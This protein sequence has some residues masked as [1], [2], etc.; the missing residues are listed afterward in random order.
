MNFC[1]QC[2]SNDIHLRIPEGDTFPRY[3][4][5]MCKTV[6]YQNPNMIT[7]AIPVWEG[8][9]LLARRGIEPRKGFW[10][11]PCGFLE[12]HETIEE[13]A[14]REVKEETGIDI[15]LRQLHTVY[16]LPHANQVYI[17]FVAEMVHSN[18]I[19]TPESTEIK[20]FA[21][22]EL[23]WDEIAFSSN[24]YALKNYIQDLESG[25]NSVHLGTF[26]KAK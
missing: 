11:L 15:A 13:G 2:G 5:D 17:I 16:N 25:F 26:R 23:P 6:H 22:N 24:T 9:I 19:L 18:F 12:L 10:N 3:S 1:S 21:L 14:I 20:L 7:G 8:K 4:C